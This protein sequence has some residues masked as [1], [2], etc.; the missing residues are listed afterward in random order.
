MAGESS[1]GKKGKAGRLL[2]A[3]PLEA[4][5]PAPVQSVPPAPI[6]VQA[7][8][9][10]PSPP[11]PIPVDVSQQAAAAGPI[12]IQPAAAAPIPVQSSP[13]APVPAPT[14]PVAPSPNRPVVVAPGTAGP[15]VRQ[16]RMPQPAG[17]QRPADH[18]PAKQTSAAGG[19]ARP[20]VLAEAQKKQRGLAIA[21]HG[22]KPGRKAVGVR[23]EIEEREEQGA[24][25]L[26]WQNLVTNHRSML[27]SAVVHAIGF[28]VLAL[29]M[30]PITNRQI[31]LLALAPNPEEPDFEDEFE[32]F[33][34]EGPDLH[35]ESPDIVDRL[36][37]EALQPLIDMKNAAEGVDA[38]SVELS[39]TGLEH[40]PFND[41]LVDLGRGTGQAND[42]GTGKGKQGT[43]FGLS[44]DGMGL[45]GRGG[46]RGNAL[47][48]GA[49]PESE[50]AVDLALKWLADHQLPDGSWCFDHTLAPQCQGQCPNPGSMPEARI[51]A[52]A[53]G[54]LPFL[55]AGQTHQVGKY[56]KTV[57]AALNYLIARMQ[58]TPNGG[59]LY[60]P[61]GRMY[62][63]GLAT[64]ALCE[65]YGMNLAPDDAGKLH[66]GEYD[67]EGAKSPSET[68]E[69]KEVKLSERE[70]NAI[71]GLARRLGPAAQAALNYVM[72]AQDTA[73]GG[74]RYE[75]R[76]AGDTS[77]VGWQLMAL[78]SGRLAYLKVDPRSFVAATIFLNH[79]QTDEY[80]S[81]YGYTGPDR[82][83][84]ATQAIGLLSRMYL[85]WTRDHPGLTQGVQNMS[86]AGPSGGNMYYNYYATQVLHHYGGDVWKRWNNVMRDR[87]IHS[88][89]HNGHTTGSWYFGGGGH[90]A[91]KGGRL[92]CTAMA[93]MTLE[94]YYRH[95]PLYGEDIFEKAEQRAA[96]DQEAAE[97]PDAFPLD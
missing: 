69:T 40:A 63:H 17:P 80:G 54:V 23:E 76:Q 12:P 47:K 42:R 93:A 20:I 2:K 92:Y 60:E 84:Q 48:R 50:A 66:R 90:G 10:V 44:G 31:S 14:V 21:E 4:E 16:P 67:G 97:K 75:P 38:A 29:W 6:P 26:W 28:V 5:P 61:G 87:L 95:M 96:G 89:S 46:R 68:N 59:S 19:A 18:Q 94:V 58:V 7:P 22:W 15:T 53:F 36:E 64:I 74:W 25:A 8:P 41:I 35:S 85:G 37:P 78:M 30:L 82:K 73:G 91:P 79:V 65:A 45:G 13:A 11:A 81:D 86:A 83:T 71:R 32:I 34:T 33:E 55:G 49:T 9:A 57:A 88:Q 77:V 51:G 52:T 39:P 27:V 24:L 72:Y 3:K 56:K 62:S 1:S 43:G 70:K